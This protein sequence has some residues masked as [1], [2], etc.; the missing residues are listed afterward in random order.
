MP[1]FQN[2]LTGGLILLS[3][4]I[5]PLSYAQGGTTSSAVVSQEVKLTE[6]SV[7]ATRTRRETDEV[8]ATVSVI[9]E[10]AI[11]HDLTQNI[12]DLIRYEPGV[13]VPASPARFGVE[14][15]TTLVAAKDRVDTSTG[16][17]F[18]S[19]GYGLVD[20][21]GRYNFSRQAAFNFG[22]FNL[23]D[24]KYWHWSD[25]RGQLATGAMLDRF[26]QP[27]RNASASFRYQ[28]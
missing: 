10:T 17:L 3:V 22:V 16:N 2:G 23:F 18:K 9:D 4:A 28:F 26:T 15:A 13:S 8:P 5:P 12:K 1:R 20:V 14:I 11:E 21:F 27:G 25:V 6:V 24:K 19:P 7:T